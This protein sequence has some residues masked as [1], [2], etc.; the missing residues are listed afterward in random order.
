[1]IKPL[2][3]DK[4]ACNREDCDRAS[5]CWR[6]EGGKVRN[7]DRGLFTEVSDPASCDIFLPISY[8]F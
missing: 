3:N 7:S 1:M 8:Y 5:K 4:S 6:Y 2:P